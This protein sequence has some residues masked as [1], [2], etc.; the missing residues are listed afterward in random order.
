MKKE[1]LLELGFK[2]TTYA[3][4]EQFTLEINEFVKI[5]YY[6]EIVDISIS[7]IWTNVPNCKTIADMKNLINLFS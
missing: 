7:Y 4:F 3:D 1:E 5:E 6:N 2:D